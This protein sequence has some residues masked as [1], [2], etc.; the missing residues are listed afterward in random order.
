VKS[1]KLIVYVIGFM[2]FSAIT[3]SKRG[4]L[5]GF[6]NWLGK[7]HF[8]RERLTILL[9]LSIIVYTVAFSS[10]SIQ[11]H[12]AYNTR[13]WDLGIFTQSLWTTL[14]A[15]RFLY[16]T[17]ELIVNPSGAFFGVHFSP[18]LFLILPLYGIVQSPS[19]L[20]VLQSFVLSL[21]AIPIFKL[22]SEKS[23]NR[24]V[25][26]VFALAYLMYPPIHHVN[27]YDFHVQA[28]LPFFFGYTIYSLSKGDWTKYFVFVFLSLMCEEHVAWIVF[29]IGF[30]VGWK[31]RKGII[32]ALKDKVF[33]N[34]KL[35]VAVSTMALSVV[36]YLFTLWQRDTFFP[37]NP[38][39]MIEFLGSG[40]F[41]ILGASNP[42]EVPILI[43]LK[44]WNAIQSLA[45]DGLLKIAF[46]V[47][48]FGP[49]AFLSFKSPSSLIPAIPSF[50][51]SLFSQSP[52]HHILG[53]QYPA[54]FAF[55]IFGAAIL[56]LERQSKNLKRFL[57]VIVGSSLVFFVCLSPFFPTVTLFP[58][59]YDIASFG[60][61][62]KL[63]NEVLR[64]VPANAS[65][66]TQDNI[67]PHVSHRVDA[68]V[69]P[70]RW[71]HSDIREIAV[72]FTNQ[73]MDRVEYVLVDSRTDFLAYETVLFLLSSK[74]QF[75]LETSQD[76]GTILLYRQELP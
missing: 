27:V 50:V 6:E 1:F 61:H 20:F 29:F 41:G 47:F 51:F 63:L 40:N 66:L 21:A 44:P 25:G 8:G 49:L 34:R 59:D 55:F 32:V 64:T 9:T 4:I 31:N 18:I 76:N 17:C 57:T 26:L 35:L 46:I 23:G 5:K 68:Y 58:T 13:A 71:I 53:T 54:Y 16:Y 48:M 22:A 67:F 60:E 2:V 62:E 11:R 75:S 69:V 74:P 10:L 42:L 3:G 70:D 36:W 30:Y 37:V 73:T 14:N 15:N 38:A 65:I 52:F 56:G 43:I 7:K 33:T 28:F 39:T 19:T 24:T 12:Y 45:N 72:E